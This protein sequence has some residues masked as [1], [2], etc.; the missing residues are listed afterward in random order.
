MFMQNRIFW[1]ISL[2][3]V[4]GGLFFWGVKKQVMPWNKYD[5]KLDSLFLG[6]RFGMTSQAFFDRCMVL[7][8]EGK[9]IQGSHNTSVLYIDRENFKLPVDMNFYPAFMDDKMFAM[10]LYFNYKAWAPW[11]RELQSDVLILEVKKLMEKWFGPGFQEKKLA[12]G[13]V[14]YY[15]ID[16][17]RIV[18]IKIRDEQ[19]VDVLI[20][21]L[22]YGTDDKATD[23][24]K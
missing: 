4:V 5:H 15:K 2:L 22:N 19:Y 23:E 16:H 1:L 7:N 21:N 12:S 13:R 17:P 8:K 24:Q 3:L 11:N 14:G 9:T 6:L 10:P 20:E 18:T